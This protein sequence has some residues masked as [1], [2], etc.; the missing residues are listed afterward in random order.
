MFEGKFPSTSPRGGGGG[1]QFNEGLFALPVLGLKFGGL[2]HG[3]AYFWNFS[4]Y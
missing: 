4:V 1:R 3:G 2:I